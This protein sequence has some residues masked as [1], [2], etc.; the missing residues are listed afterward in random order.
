MEKLDSIHRILLIK[1]RPNALV[2]EDHSEKEISQWACAFSFH[3]RT[4]GEVGPWILHPRCSRSPCAEEFI[5]WY[6]ANILP[7]KYPAFKY[8]FIATVIYGNWRHKWMELASAHWIVKRDYMYSI[9]ML[10]QTQ[11]NHE[12]QRWRE[13]AHTSCSMLKVTI[14]KYLMLSMIWAP[15]DWLCGWV[16]DRLDPFSFENSMG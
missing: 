11:Q 16:T 13:P 8:G 7:S 6:P 9:M 2:S 14:T 1:R 4:G 15:S 3:S 5:S 10:Y 12:L